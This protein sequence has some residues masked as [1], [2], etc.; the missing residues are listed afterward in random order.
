MDS[1]RSKKYV[2]GEYVGYDYSSSVKVDYGYKGKLTIYIDAN[3]ETVI[4]FTIEKPS[5]SLSFSFEGFTDRELGKLVFYY[6]NAYRSRLNIEPLIWS[7]KVY[8]A[9]YNHTKDMFERDFFAHDSP[10]EGFWERATRELGRGYKS[11]VIF[12]SQGSFNPIHA[13]VGWMKSSPGHREATLSNTYK[14]AGTS[15]MGTKEEMRV[16]QLYFTPLD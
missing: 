2:N 8:Q 14:Y 10:T 12:L 4:G 15:L 13:L 3:L 5:E 11:E 6:T 9:A 16:T 7:E 1:G